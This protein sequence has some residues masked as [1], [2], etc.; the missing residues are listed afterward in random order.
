LQPELDA[1]V[2]QVLGVENSLQAFVSYGSTAPQE[3]ARQIE[4]WK[5]QISPLPVDDVTTS[6]ATTL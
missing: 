1:S 6:S 5:Q 2:Y 4:R 3:V